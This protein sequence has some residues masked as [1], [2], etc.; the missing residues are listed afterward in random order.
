[1]K[2]LNR[3]QHQLGVGLIEVLVALVVIAVGFIAV[4]GLQGTLMS[5]SSHHQGQG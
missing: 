3:R 5:G 1:M 2:I 4:L